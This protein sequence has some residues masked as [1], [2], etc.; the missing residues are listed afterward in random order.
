M[1]P[2]STAIG[3]KYS[4]RGNGCNFVQIKFDNIS[5]GLSR[6]KKYIELGANFISFAKL[7]DNVSN[8]LSRWKN[9][10]HVNFTNGFNRWKLI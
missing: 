9:K 5:N 8:G 4:E 7:M 3:K 1:F 10:R 2:T 6:W